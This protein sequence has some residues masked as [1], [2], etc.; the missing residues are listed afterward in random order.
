MN[1]H[2]I[3]KSAMAAGSPEELLKIT[4]ENGMN[5]FTEESANAYYELL[6]KSGELS[7]DE[8]ESAAG[9]CMKGGRRVVTIM[10]LCE[11]PEFWRCKRCKK[12]IRDCHCSLPFMSDK[13]ECGTCDWC[14]YE[15]GMWYCNNETANR[16]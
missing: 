2:E 3:M 7:D 4:R 9:G 10:N 6:H 13:R 1:K 11:L 5:G 14:S 8:L 15:K 12:N 16:D